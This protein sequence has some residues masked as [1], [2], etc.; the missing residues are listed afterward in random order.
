VYCGDQH[1]KIIETSIDDIKGTLRAK[2]VTIKSLNQAP[3]DAQ[4][5]EKYPEI[6]VKIAP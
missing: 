6:K 2:K 3:K 5:A 1:R 4:Q